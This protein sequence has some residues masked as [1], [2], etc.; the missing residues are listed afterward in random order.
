MNVNMLNALIFGPHEILDL[1]LTAVYFPNARID[2]RA[3]RAHTCSMRLGVLC[4]VVSTALASLSRAQ[5]PVFAITHDE[6][7]IKFYVKASVAIV[8]S[9][10]KWDSTLTFTSPDVTTG[11]LDVKIQAASVNTGSGMK[12]G[13]LKGKD[14]FDVKQNPLITFRSKKIEQ[15]GPDTFDVLGDF[16]IRGVS[17]PE[18]LKLTVSG[19]GT[20]SGAIKGTMAFD[21]KAYGMTSGIPFIK[22]ADRVE[23]NVDLKGK[24]VSGPPLVFKQ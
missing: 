12:D 5:A 18:V 23:V 24:R 8:G 9:F 4:L 11:V 10:E 15:T 7:T 3:E 17:K 16:T 14:F 13:K 6:S 20:G 19:K 1:G 21:R 2:S 22:I